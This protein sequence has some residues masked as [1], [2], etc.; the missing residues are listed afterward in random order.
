M[1]GRVSDFR[2]TSCDQGNDKQDKEH[3]KENLCDPCG[4]SGNVSKSKNGSDDGNH[5]EDDGIM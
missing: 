2:A 4:S 1:M 3:Q 5:E